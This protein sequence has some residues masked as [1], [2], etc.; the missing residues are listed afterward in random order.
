MPFL[1]LLR[2]CVLLLFIFLSCR[3]P[4][5]RLLRLR[6][7]LQQVSDLGASRT[8]FSQLL[9]GCVSL[10]LVLFLRITHLCNHCVCLLNR[11]YFSIWECYAPFAVVACLCLLQRVFF[12]GVTPPICSY[13]VCLRTVRCGSI[14]PGLQ[15][16]PAC[17]YCCTFSFWELHP[18]CSYCVCLPN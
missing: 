2:A 10:L 5:L 17:V 3:A 12:S 18:C 8:P 15:L 16:L 6:A 7:K 14:A 9:C 1:Q 11:N 4:Q 13:C